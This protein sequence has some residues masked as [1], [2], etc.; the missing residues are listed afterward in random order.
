MK[1][2]LF[3]LD[4]AEYII[5]HLNG[6]ACCKIASNFL[7][8]FINLFISIVFNLDD[9]EDNGNHVVFKDMITATL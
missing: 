7:R 4:L 5:L 9:F 2:E 8:Y 3:V 1:L 6:V